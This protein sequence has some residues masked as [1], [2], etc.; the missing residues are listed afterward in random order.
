MFRLRAELA[1][2]EVVMSAATVSR[3]SRSRSGGSLKN[4]IVIQGGEMCKKVQ[5]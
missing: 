5:I 2:M 3:E 1:A 4:R